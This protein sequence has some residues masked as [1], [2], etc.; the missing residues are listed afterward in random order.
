MSVND[1]CRLC[2]ENLRIK[3]YIG[4]SKKIFHKDANEKSVD[5]RLTELGL[6]LLN[7]R[8]NPCRICLRCFRLI[9]TLSTFKRWQKAEEAPSSE[10]SSSSMTTATSE[11]A[12][13]SVAHKRDRVPTPS[14][15]CP[16]PPTPHCS[17]SS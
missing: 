9:G 17:P 5:E 16:H 2:Y 12:K 15:L 8:E 13:V 6:K 10:H 11:S 7:V 3:G 1:L 4:Y 14:K